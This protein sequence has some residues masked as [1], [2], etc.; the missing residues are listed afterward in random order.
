VRQIKVIHNVGEKV[1]E[2]LRAI[3]KVNMKIKTVSIT[4]SAFFAFFTSQSLQAQAGNKLN[5]FDFLSL[6]M[7][8]ETLR[9]Q[10]RKCDAL[11]DSPGFEGSSKVGVTATVCPA[12]ETF[13]LA[14]LFHKKLATVSVNWVSWNVKDGSGPSDRVMQI[15]SELRKT[16]GTPVATIAYESKF[17]NAD[18]DRYCHEKGDCRIHF[19]ESDQPTRVASLVYAV[20]PNGE[21]PLIFHLADLEA[22]RQIQKLKKGDSDKDEGIDQDDSSPIVPLKTRTNLHF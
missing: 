18:A 22:E 9:Q 6:G 4:A 3:G 2:T 13:A 14:T 16:Y 5:S 17:G 10:G 20:V 7:N 12:A 19:W 8:Y 21:I 1:R 11:A 15:A